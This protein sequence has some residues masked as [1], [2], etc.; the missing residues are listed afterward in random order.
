MELK[1]KILDFMYRLEAIPVGH[2][3][4]L[5]EYLSDL[6]KIIQVTFTS[7][8]PYLN[9]LQFIKFKP[10]TVFVTDREREQSWQ[11]GTTQVDN[12]LRVLLN[13]P[14]I[15]P[16]NLSWTMSKESPVLDSGIEK[17]LEEFNRSVMESQKK[18][19]DEPFQEAPAEHTL[20][21]MQEAVSQSLENLQQSIISEHPDLKD[22]IVSNGTDKSAAQD[23]NK[24]DVISGLQRVLCVTS[25]DENLN[26]EVSG[27]L[28][29]LHIE[30][31][32]IPKGGE[33]E[34]LMDRMNQCLNADFVVFILSADFHMYARS[35]RP[36]D[37]SLAAS[38]SAAFQLGYL[39]A[40]FDRKHIIV[41]YREET[42]FIM[43]TEFFD[44]L[45]IAVTATG[46]WKEDVLHRMKGKQE[47]SESLGLSK[48]NNGIIS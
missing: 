32:G 11:N 9:Y 20:E 37:A 29:L 31:I 6:K 26:A 1:K 25:T 48:K 27:F 12:L 17:S 34:T 41:L 24:K 19:F 7:Q 45:Y 35:Q 3:S 5:K 2:E 33:R 15:N 44:L 46:H 8:S 28:N 30:V 36:A 47:I 21:N 42:E 13:D 43:P 23:L 38:Q 16:Q 39:A 4:L 18:I 40:K 22:Q 10:D 14:K